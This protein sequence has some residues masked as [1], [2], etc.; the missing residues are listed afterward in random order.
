MCGQ[1][2][3]NKLEHEVMFAMM[4]IITDDDVNIKSWYCAMS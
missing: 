4:M 2:V 1:F 3:L